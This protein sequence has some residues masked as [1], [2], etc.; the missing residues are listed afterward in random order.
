MRLSPFLAVALVQFVCFSIPVHAEQD[1]PPSPEQQAV[2]ALSR[3]R[4]NIQFN[5]DGTTRLLR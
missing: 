4:T 2:D 5:K 1:Q 3:L